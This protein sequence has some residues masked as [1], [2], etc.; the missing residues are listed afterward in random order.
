MVAPAWMHERI[1]AEQYDSWST[2]QCAAGS[3]T[4]DRTVKLEQ[5]AR[6]GIPVYW[7]I[8]Q[9]ATAT[10]IAYTYLLDPALGRHRE[11]DVCPGVI[12]AAAPFPVEVDLRAV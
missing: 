3:E 2:E 8:E 1:T 4:T 10:C 6:A 9:I 11:G 12:K 5:Y 7:R